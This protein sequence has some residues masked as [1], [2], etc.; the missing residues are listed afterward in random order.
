M[1]ILP[2][3]LAAD[4]GH[5]ADETARCEAA[6]ADA[7]HID[8]MDGHFVPNLNF[9]PT[10]VA[11]FRRATKL[12]LDVHLMLERPDLYAMRFAEAGADAISIHVEAPCDI[13]ATLRSIRERGLRAGIV[14]KPATAADAVK[15][16]IGLFDY[17]LVMTVEPGYGG[18]KFMADMLPKIKALATMTPKFPI[19][20]DGGISATTAPLC[21]EAGATEL[22][23]GSALFGAKDMAAA[24]SAMRG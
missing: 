14:L 6:G 12:H 10:V 5:L 22:V 20:V 8:V 11:A 21:I 7:L 4:Y 24:I 15:P 18:Q 19:M 16:F 13:A 23:A 2:S 9:G 17:V 1:T 3:M